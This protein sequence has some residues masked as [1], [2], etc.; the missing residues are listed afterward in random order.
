MILS[1]EGDCRDKSCLQI[2]GD[3]RASGTKSKKYNVIFIHILYFNHN[4]TPSQRV[5]WKEIIF[6]LKKL[7]LF[8]D[9]MSRIFTQNKTEAV[10]CTLKSVQNK[11]LNQNVWL[12]VAFIILS[13]ASSSSSIIF[14]RKYIIIRHKMNSCWCAAR[15]RI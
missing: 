13:H 1:Q 14:S 10:N 8:L 12:R 6:F 3:Y 15:S 2:V 11:R 4:K 5:S 9:Q 7:N